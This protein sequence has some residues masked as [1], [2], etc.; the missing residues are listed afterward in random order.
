MVAN[1][2]NYIESDFSHDEETCIEY[3]RRMAVR[4][5]KSAIRRAYRRLVPVH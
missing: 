4:R 1:T 2:L 5:P 3:R